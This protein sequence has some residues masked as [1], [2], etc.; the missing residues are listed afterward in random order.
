MED[1]SSLSS[2]ISHIWHWSRQPIRSKH[3]LAPPL[4]AELLVGDIAKY[5]GAERSLSGK[6]LHVIKW[7]DTL[8]EIR[9]SSNIFSW[10]DIQ[11][12][13]KAHHKHFTISI[14]FK[15][16]YRVK[17]SELFVSKRYFESSTERSIKTYYYYL[18][19]EISMSGTDAQGSNFEAY[20]C[21]CL[22][23]PLSSDSLL[24]ANC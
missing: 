7:L 20:S 18:T 23:F 17:S 5:V 22:D 10:Q 13:F 24:A 11:N 12:R 6:T 4:T 19:T 15:N 16:S 21:N 3:L 1:F 9:F 8:S 14:A 2:I